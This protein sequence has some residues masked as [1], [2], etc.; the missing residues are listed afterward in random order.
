MKRFVAILSLA[1]AACSSDSATG[2]EE[3]NLTQTEIADVYEAIN[4]VGGFSL[5]FFG[6]ITLRDGAALMDAALTETLDETESC[7]EGGTTRVRG[8]VTVN[9][10]TGSGSLDMRQ[11]YTNC[12][13]EAS[14]GR[15]WTLNGDPDIRTRLTVGVSASTQQLSITG[16]QTGAFRF[17]SNGTTGRCTIDL[18]ATLTET[19]Y[20]ITGRVCGQNYSESGSFDF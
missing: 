11:S 6:G 5:N 1:L 13:V 16:T 7:P 12:A 10:T 2:P 20:S 17:S 9:E 15:V 19:S 18:R 14:S 4:A 8:S 3:A